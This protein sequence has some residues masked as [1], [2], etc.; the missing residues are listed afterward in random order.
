M[1]TQQRLTLEEYLIYDDGTDTRYEFDDGALIEMPP[2]I[3]LHRL[4]A[5]FLEQCFKREIRT[6][7]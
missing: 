2:A 1:A 7:L 3:R 6:S 5:Q 4:I